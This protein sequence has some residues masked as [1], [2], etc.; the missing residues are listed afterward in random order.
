VPAPASAQPLKLPAV[1]FETTV[2]GHTVKI[3]L[4]TQLDVKTQGSMLAVKTVAKANLADLQDKFNAI[5]T[6]LP[7]KRERCH[8]RLFVHDNVLAPSGGGAAV[9]SFRGRGELWTCTPSLRCSAVYDGELLGVK[10]KYC[11]RYES[12]EAENNIVTQPFSGAIDLAFATTADEIR[13]LVSTRRPTL[14]GAGGPLTQFVLDLFGVDLRAMLQ[15][16]LDQQVN[17]KLFGAGLPEEFKK[18]SPRYVRASFL[19]LGEKRLGVEVEFDLSVQPDQMSE[20]LRKALQG[21]RR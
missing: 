3:P 5:V 19:D 12:S 10:F 20:A 6:S 2:Y 13:P 14:E 17:P 9:A 1:P 18:F 4:E 11:G 7:L 21:E 8:I 15:G 16:M